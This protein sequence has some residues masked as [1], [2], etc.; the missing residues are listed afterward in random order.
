MLM[1]SCIVNTP[2]CHILIWEYKVFFQ[3]IFACKKA[4]GN[5][6]RRQKTSALQ[7]F[8]FCSEKWTA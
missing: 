6:M 2:R 5:M 3:H 7:H 8:P 4:K 1:N